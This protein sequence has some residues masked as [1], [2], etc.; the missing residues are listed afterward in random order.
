MLREQLR[1]AIREME[2]LNEMREEAV[3]NSR[4]LI[5]IAR[6]SIL[7]SRKF[8]DLKN[9]EKRLLESLKDVREFIG[10]LKSKYGFSESIVS[11]IQDAIQELVEGIVLCKI[12]MGDEVPNHIE[13]GVGAREYL[14]GV[15]DVVGELRRIALHYLKEG[16]VR[17]AEELIKIMEEIYEEIN[18]VIFPDSLI[19][20]R[21]KA[22]EA[23]IMIEKTISEVIFV[24]AS[25]RGEI[26]GS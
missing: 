26:E 3:R 16:N 4:R 25:R 11:V 10:E 14:L 8:R 2:E 7:E 9:V 21:R 6:N 22:D 23:R 24:K 12:L 17:G 20:L 19:P 5:S 13:L 18:S 1:L 15:S